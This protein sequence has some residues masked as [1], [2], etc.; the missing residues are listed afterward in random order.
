[1][2]NLNTKTL[3]FYLLIVVLIVAGCQQNNGYDFAITVTSVWE[4]AWESIPATQT[5]FAMKTAESQL[6]LT[7]QPS[8]MSTPTP[9]SILPLSTTMLPPITPVTPSPLEDIK[10]FGKFLYNPYYGANGKGVIDLSHYHFDH[11]LEVEAEYTSNLYQGEWSWDLK[12]VAIA[13]AMSPLSKDVRSVDLAVCI[14]N[15]Q[16]FEDH[17]IR[18]YTNILFPPVSNNGHTKIHN[19]SWSP[20]NKYLMVTVK[21]DG[22]F[23]TSP[24]LVEIDTN[25]VDCRWSLLFSNNNITN[26]PSLLSGAHAIAWSPQDKNKMAIPLKKNWL[27]L[28]LGVTNGSTLYTTMPWDTPTNDLKQGLYIVDTTPAYLYSKDDEVFT[29]LWEA[30]NGTTMD[31]EQL[32]LWT[33]DGKKIAF[34]YIDP[35]INIARDSM[36]MPI[37]NYVVGLVEESNGKFTKLFDSTDMYLSR[38]LPSGSS[39]PVIHMYKWVY[40]D[41]FLLFTATIQKNSVGEREQSL[42]LYDTETEQFFQVTS[43]T[44]IN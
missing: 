13:S 10:L 23:I 17:C 9:A 4:E 35:W 29:M 26:V 44:S 40:Q 43:W 38:I 36:Q 41:R 33:S 11:P 39:L 31:H 21:G 8:Q 20:D 16:T 27:P 1:M 25:S 18:I 34:V 24:C 2:M 15:M 14:V 22:D 3:F 42:F 28:Y 5:Q 6:E 32:P 30:P 19:I 7:L 12:Y 37:A